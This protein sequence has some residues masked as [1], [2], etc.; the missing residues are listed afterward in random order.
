MVFSAWEEAAK[1]ST[2][3]LLGLGRFIH[4]NTSLDAGLPNQSCK[5]ELLEGIPLTKHNT[6]NIKQQVWNLKSS[7]F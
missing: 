2:S 1:Q 4:L 5:E 6:G 7:A 3:K